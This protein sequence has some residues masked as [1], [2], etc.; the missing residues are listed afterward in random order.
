VPTTYY[1][2]SVHG[3]M[4]QLEDREIGEVPYYFRPVERFEEIL[5]QVG[6]V[7]LRSEHFD[8]READKDDPGYGDNYINDYL[9]FGPTVA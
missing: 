7:L 8:A 4:L 3:R 2:D 1:P 6:R 9:I 5:G